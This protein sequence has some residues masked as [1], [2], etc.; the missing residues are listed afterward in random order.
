MVGA[1]IPVFILGSHFRTL[2]I[3]LRILLDHFFPLPNVATLNKSFL[4]IST[5]NLLLFVSL[6]KTGGQIFH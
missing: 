3:D 2:D 1:V 5:I 4:S 6:I